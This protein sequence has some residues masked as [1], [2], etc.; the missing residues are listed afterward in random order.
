MNVSIRWL[1]RWRNLNETGVRPGHLKDEHY[2]S[3]KSVR[4][5]KVCSKGHLY[6]KSSDCPVCPICEKEKIIDGFH[7]ILSAPA[8]RALENAGIMTIQQLSMK[9]EKE[10]LALH[11]MGPGSIPKL[12][13]EL[14]S[15]GLSFK[16]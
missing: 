3:E 15:K 8:R 14:K 7:S 13:L 2:G 11:G 12:R 5:R 9:T 1:K 6:Y 16:K 10:I 4:T